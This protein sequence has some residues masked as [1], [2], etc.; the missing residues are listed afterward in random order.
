MKKLVLGSIVLATLGFMGCGE[1]NSDMVDGKLSTEIVDPKNPPVIEFKDTTYNFGT[2]SQ[3]EIVSYTFY[4]KNTGRSSLVLTDVR[5]SCGC[6]V[7]KSWPREPVAP[8]G[9]GKI[10]VTFD[11]A[12]KQGKVTKSIRVVANTKP[13]THILRLEGEIKAPGSKEEG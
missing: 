3:G 1:K 9:E 7:P 13:T 11:S 12:G 4:F 6:T 2:I 5:P 10:E 8:D